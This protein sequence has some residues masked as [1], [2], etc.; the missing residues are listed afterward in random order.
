[1]FLDEFFIHEEPAPDDATHVELEGAP[2]CGGGARS[3]E[4]RQRRVESLREHRSQLVAGGGIFDVFI[5][6]G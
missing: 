1:M 6:V 2:D 4:A 3:S 5:S